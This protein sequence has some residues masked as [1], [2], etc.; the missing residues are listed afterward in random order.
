[1][2]G[3]WLQLLIVAVLV[4][5]NA[6]FSGT[7]IALISLREGQ[8]RRLEEEGET[9]AVIGRLVRDPNQFLATIQVGITLAGF[10]ASAFAA[11]A[12]A[13]PLVE[14]LGFLGGAAEP[15]AI[16]LVTIALTFVTL[17]VDELAPKRIAMQRAERWAKIAARPLS[18]L[19]RLVRPVVL[20]L[21]WSTDLLVRLLG[22]DP[23]RTQSEVTADEVREFVSTQ[24][25]FTP[26]HRTIISGAVEIGDRVLREIMIPRRDVTTL[27]ADD[28]AADGLQALVVEGR[29]RAPVVEGDELDDVIGVVHLS[30]L[31]EAATVRAAARPP[32]L[33]PEGMRVLDALN[34][35]RAER[36]QLGIVIDEYGGAEGIVTVEDLL[37]EI[38]GE[39]YDETDV[40]V[41]AARRRADGSFLLSGAFPMHDLIDIGV[42]LPEGD[43]TTIAGFMLDQLGRIPEARGESVDVGRWRLIVDGLEGRAISRVSLHPLAPDHEGTQ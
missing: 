9:G 38:V 27:S 23:S 15:I 1:M 18:G 39:I 37:E 14:P 7:E 3:P 25:L 29:S 36:K 24:A 17:V 43:Y 2:G 26:E 10:L 20:L 13:E 30:D 12:I 5:V 21:S 31:T 4:L 42:E 22:S 35:L 32:V 16:V 33:L 8:L 41:A 40:R 11:V 34:R 6:V 19:A 28:S